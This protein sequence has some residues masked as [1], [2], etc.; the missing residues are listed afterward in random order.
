MSKG[1]EVALRG[2]VGDLTD[3][4]FFPSNEV[5]LTASS[6]MTLRIFSALDGSAP[7]TL[8]GHT[9]R[10]TALHILASTSASGPHKGRLVLSS[11]LDGTLRLWDVASATNT[12]TWTLTQPISALLVFQSDDTEE[13]SEDVL[14]GKVA[15]AAHTD[16]TV[17]RVDLST[18]P[19]SSGMAPAPTVLKSASA[20]PIETLSK[21]GNWLAAGSRNGVVALYQLPPSSIQSSIEPLIEWTR[22]E[23]G[24]SISDVRFSSC[25]STAEP[26]IAPAGASA[27]SCPPRSLL[28]ASSDGLAYR[29][30]LSLPSVDAK[31]TGSSEQVDVR[32]VEEF[33]GPDCE[34]TTCIREDAAGRVWI[35]AGGTDGG[36]RVYERSVRV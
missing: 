20:S 13:D 29:A 1:K 30:A 17:S 2:H 25:E 34:P 31:E 32:V 36:L 6:D 27:T 24:S 9:K 15:L 4:A 33:V 14:K 26:D 35:S 28:V 16:G 5:V 7:R 12:Q 19:P 11:S 8:K 18:P 3:A 21:M 22:T 10:I 23:G